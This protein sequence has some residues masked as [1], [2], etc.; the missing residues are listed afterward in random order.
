MNNL[1]NQ[2]QNIY[3]KSLNGLRGLATLVVFLLMPL[4]FLIQL[5]LVNSCYLMELLQ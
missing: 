1:N 4:A 3:F 2:N 5:C